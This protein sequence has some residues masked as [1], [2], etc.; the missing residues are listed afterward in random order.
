MIKFGLLVSLVPHSD[1][2]DDDNN[3]DLDIQDSSEGNSLLYIIPVLLP[4]YQNMN[5]TNNYN[6]IANNIQFN[7]ICSF[8]FTTNLK[9]EKYS[10]ITNNDLMT[11]G[12]LPNGLFERLL[13]KVIRWSQYTG[14]NNRRYVFLLYLW[15]IFF[16][17]QL[18]IYIFVD[19]RFIVIVIVIVIV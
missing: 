18:F 8:V 11:L 9:L 15:F 2:D 4:S 12:F 17:F 7:H 6:D 5:N 1:N 19:L 13:C 14:S 10:T 16:L 3:N